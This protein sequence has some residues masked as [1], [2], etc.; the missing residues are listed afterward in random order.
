MRPTNTATA[1]FESTEDRRKLAK[2]NSVAMIA[3]ANNA[4]PHVGTKCIT[5]SRL[6]V[7]ERI[8]TPDGLH[9]SA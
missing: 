9:F 6:A 7:L 1:S 2:S 3:R 4:K 5:Y 8:S